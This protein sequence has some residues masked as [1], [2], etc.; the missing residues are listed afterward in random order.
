MRTI[1]KVKMLLY[2]HST[3]LILVI[4]LLLIAIV[5]DAFGK[6]LIHRIII[7]MFINLSLVLG[8][9]VYMGNGGI[10]NFSHIGFMGIGAYASVLFSMSPQAKALTLPDLYPFLAPIHLPFGLSLLIG[11]LIA[12]TI[13][14]MVGFPLM[15]ISEAAAVITTFALLVIIH[16]VLVQW[17]E[18]T[19]GPQTLFGVDRYTYLWTSALW[20]IGFI[21]L[22]YWFKESAIGLKLRASRDD[23]FAASTCG[24]NIVYVRWI[25]FTLSAFMAGI[26]GGLWAHF[27][28]SFSPKAFY[29]T[30]TFV[31]LTML[32]IGGPGGV[33]GAVV[34]T[35]VITSIR[36]GLRAI[37]NWININS[38]TSSTLVGFTEVFLAIILILL[39]IIRPSGIMGGRELRWPLRRM[40]IDYNQSVLDQT[41]KEEVEGVRHV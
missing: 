15:R 32:V 21:A 23:R 27:I 39:L 16:V 38:I 18:L 25:A 31:I 36:E 14:A 6:T 10:L 7:T 22:S 33:S 8:L 20:G 11:A 5:T 13:A 28:T 35:V 40:K 9:Q 37:E 12:A 34:G 41:L 2:R 24:I 1:P 17:G 30:E 29:L 3:V 26:G 19:N 4:P